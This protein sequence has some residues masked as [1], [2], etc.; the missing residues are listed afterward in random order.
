MNYK[1]ITYLQSINILGCV[2]LMP[3]G[4]HGIC[5]KFLFYQ[6]GN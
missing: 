4:M 3:Y 6:R 2:S 1:G 5:C